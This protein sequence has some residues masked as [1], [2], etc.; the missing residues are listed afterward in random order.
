MRKTKIICTIGPA[1]EDE[2]VL[3]KMCQAG[4][5]VARLNFSHGSH[6]EHLGK[7]KKIKKVREK[8]GY[9]LPIMLDTKGPEYRI[10]D[11]KNG[12]ETL[13]DGQAFTFTTRD[14]SGDNTI[15][16]VNYADLVSELKTGDRIL[17]NNGLLIFEVKELTV[18]DVICEVISGVEIP[19]MEHAVEILGLVSGDN[20]TLTGGQTSKQAGSTNTI[21]LETIK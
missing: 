13:T 11:F 6:D 1:N 15:V 18:T 12:K 5:N 10:R 19:F 8:L 9:P 7:I 3:E 4:M 2:E 16:S 14:L 21:R 20:I 17:V